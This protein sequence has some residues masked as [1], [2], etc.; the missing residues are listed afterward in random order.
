M[1]GPGFTGSSIFSEK[2]MKYLL[3]L[4]SVLALALP[5]AKGQSLEATFRNPPQQARPQVWW[6]W[7]DGNITQ[8]G[9]RADIEWMHRSGIAGFHQ[10]DAGGAMMQMVQPVQQQVPYMQAEWKDCF[11]T[12]VA[13]AD[14]LDMEVTIASAPGW[15]STG[16]PW[17]K[18]EQAMK[19]LTW[20][21]LE[22]EGGDRKP[23][24]IDLP[25]PYT[26]IGRFQNQDAGIY[27]QAFAYFP[28]WYQDV[29]VVAVRLP[30]EELTLAQ[31]GATV[32]SSGGQFTIGMLSNGDLSDGAELPLNPTGS[33]AWLQISFPQ[34]QT[35]RAITLSGGEHRDGFAAS[36][37]Y[38]HY[39]QSSDNGLD[40]SDVCRI[41]SCGVQQITMDIPTTTARHFRLQ[42]LNPVA[43]MSYAAF[44]VPVVQPTGTRIHELNL[45]SVV[46]VNHAEEK[47]GF[48]APNDLR[49]HPTPATF[50]PVQEVIDLTSFC[51]EGRLTWQVPAG[52]WRIYR[53]GTSLTGKTNH[54]A[55]PEATGL[56]VD[57]LD[58]IAWSEYFRTYLA[59]YRQAAG[60][61][62]DYLLTDSYEAEQMTWTPAMQ[63]EFG[64]RRGYNLVPWMPV[65]AGEVVGSSEQSEQF[66]FDWRET[67]GELFVEN[68][69]RIN[70]LVAEFGMKGRYTESHEGGR[71]YVGD[72]MD[73]KRTAA[74]PMSAIW[75]DGSTL[76]EADI[77]ESASVA[78]LYGQ[79]L[80]AAES[81]TAN[82]MGGQA[83]GFYPGN[84]KATADLALSCGLN[85]FV[86]HESPHQPSDS[87]RP[88]LGLMIFGQWFSRHETWADYARYW[89]D[90]LARSCYMLQQGHAVADILWYYGEDNNITGLYGT[91][92]P[93]VPAGYAYD[94]I[95]P[96]GLLNLLSVRDGSL[97]TASGMSY[98][99][100]VL[101]PNCQVM[102][103][104]VLRKLRQLV[105]EGAIVCGSCPQRPSGLLDDRDEFDRLVADIWHSGRK[106]VHTASLK[107]TLASHNIGPDLV[108]SSTSDIRYVHRQDGQRHIYWV[109]NFTDREADVRLQ[110]RNAIARCLVLNPETGQPLVGVWENQKLHLDPRQALF[111]VFDPQFGEPEP[112][113]TPTP[114]G[115]V[116]LDDAW[117]VTFTGLDAP[118][119]PL[120]LDKLHSL[121][122]SEDPAVR[123]FSGTITYSNQFTLSKKQCD[124]QLDI[125]LGSVG[126]MADVW[127]N[128]EHVGFLWKNPYRITYSGPLHKGKNTIEVR[129][130]NLWPNRLI[131]DAIHPESKSTYTVIPFYG[132]QSPLLPSGLMGPVKLAIF[133]KST[134]HQL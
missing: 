9:I 77:R 89:T 52:R 32:S 118:A 63:Q 111:L 42:V 60:R 49:D 46:K 86:I 54:P 29:A 93:A 19:K 125:D 66:L 47:A 8:S 98:R 99:V 96:H 12:A 115:E 97:V 56:E 25:E 109:C 45:H 81:F 121:T 119:A 104:E 75:T 87:L 114:M 72:G 83:Y 53:F 27:A 59:M 65:L 128:G 38:G 84:L 131:G 13:M 117:Q 105:G 70:Q 50:T 133:A 123:Y 48:T 30:D 10:F 100:L 82:G 71:L 85:R 57:K 78:H 41:P 73:L 61:S 39:L 43:D 6:H 34:P 55:P 23:R 69:D 51:H 112:C 28:Q 102:S 110:L 120:V 26:T 129:V 62:L 107:Q 7:I 33:H 5:H 122:E 18:P 95:Q 44:G 101:D 124:C 20:R 67:L 106:N 2:T 113:H 4:L 11:R 132:P 31:R 91:E 68:Y 17:V 16:G 14:S 36:A 74:V 76:A 134:S 35:I 127:I 126:Q 22:V 21:T 116:A 15:S 94:F 40:W 3:P 37:T 90:Y 103:I 58:P 88:G 1:L 79:N 92:L 130:V 80:V 24:Q 108:C 64:A